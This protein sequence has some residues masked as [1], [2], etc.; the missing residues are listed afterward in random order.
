M[1]DNKLE[2]KIAQIQAKFPLRSRRECQETLEVVNDDIEKALAFLAYLGPRV[3]D[4]QTQ[5]TRL[6]VNSQE[7]AST[8]GVAGGDVY[9][10]QKGV[11]D[12]RRME[13]T[14]LE[15]EQRSAPARKPGTNREGA[16]PS[17][18]TETG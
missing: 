8:Q 12:L 4:S 14:P 5:E 6:E 17:M 15:M 16:L 11:L 9:A 3:P 1:E 18:L 13:W 10:R 2:E 7:R